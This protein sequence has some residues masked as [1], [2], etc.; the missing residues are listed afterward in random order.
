M[1]YSTV[2]IW[3]LISSGGADGLDYLFN[4]NDVIT[5]GKTDGFDYLANGNNAL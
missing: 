4:G 3:F 5:S 2:I 1:I